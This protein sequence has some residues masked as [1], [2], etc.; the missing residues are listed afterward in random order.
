M[1][2][3][4]RALALLGQAID[5]LHVIASTKEPQ[6]PQKLDRLFGDLRSIHRSMQKMQ[7]SDANAR[8]RFWRLQRRAV[9]LIVKAA[10]RLSAS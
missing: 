7:L 4:R 5:R 6:D 9:V 1:P 3:A 2:P 8:R 10:E